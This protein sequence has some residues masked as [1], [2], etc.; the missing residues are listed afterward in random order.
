[1]STLV[2]GG[3]RVRVRLVALSADRRAAIVLLAFGVLLTA[4]TWNTWGDLGRDTGY[5]LVAASR[6][7]HGQLPYADFTYYYGPLAPFVLGFAAWLGGGGFA[8]AV[9]VGLLTVSLT[10]SLTYLLARAFVGALG[11]ALAGA[12]VLS[13][14]LAPTNFSYVLP[15]T[16]S[17]T[18]GVAALVGMLLALTRSRK[19]IAG[20]CLGIVALTK[21]EFELAAIAA[22]AAWC[23]SSRATLRDCARLALPA[24]AI[25]AAVYGAFLTQVSLHT[26]VFDNLYPTAVLR[27]GGDKLLR[28]HAPL[29]A[30]SLVHHAEHIALYA[31]GAGA[32]LA[33]G[34]VVD[35]A[36]RRTRLALAALAV[37]AVVVAFA[38]LEA[39]RSALQLVYGWIP[40]GALLAAA[41]IA[42][43]RRD[44]SDE[45][46]LSVALAIAGGTTYAAFYFLSTRAQTAVYF[47][48]LAAVFLAVLHLRALPRTRTQVALGAGWLAFLAAVGIALAV[49][50]AR[51]ETVALATPHGTVKVASADA[52][53]YAGALAAVDRLTVAG[54]PVLFA[55]QL[56]ALYVLSGRPDPLAQ[57][58]LLPGALPSVPAER[59][60]IAR[61]NAKHVRVIVTDTRTFAEYGNGSFGTSFDQTL[62]AWIARNFNRSGTYPGKTHTLVVWRRSAS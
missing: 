28:L 13:V 41:I 26:L 3:S 57:I 61:L 24:V 60:A 30:S 1:V 55:P 47:A 39:T 10:V 29:T 2:L 33:L 62:A 7:A 8:P 6:V 20:L 25:P 35:G 16:S 37:A 38:D 53:A 4:L 15:H 11:A 54:E 59:H 32:L 45:L 46:A 40:G 44:S 56:S 48:P 19:V 31:I 49:K 58:S 21:P 42:V 9:V 5:D 17:M 27:A 12:I 43:R 51:A 34:A 23:V 18:F 22:A 50:D 52:S 36:G 14:A